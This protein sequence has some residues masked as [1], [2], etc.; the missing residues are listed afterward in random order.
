MAKISST[1]YVAAENPEHR[2]ASTRILKVSTRIRKLPATRRFRGR[3]GVT[4]ALK[5]AETEVETERRV[6]Q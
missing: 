1:E 3:R 5:L 4:E 2:E 6:R